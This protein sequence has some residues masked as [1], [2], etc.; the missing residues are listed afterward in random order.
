MGVAGEYA[1]IASDVKKVLYRLAGETRKR[2]LNVCT[3]S[4]T[5]NFAGRMLA[6]ED[7]AT[8][9]LEF[10]AGVVTGIQMKSGNSRVIAIE[11]VDV[12]TM[13]KRFN[14]R[15]VSKRI[16]PKVNADLVPDGYYIEEPYGNIRYED[17]AISKAAAM[18]GAAFLQKLA[19]TMPVNNW[20]RVEPLGK[21]Q[22]Q[23]F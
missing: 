4:S 1:E 13:E 6:W 2:A 16:D 19:A 10:A 7:R 5:K 18:M 8:Q 3:S 22:C 11:A 15:F 14:C 23:L 17:N 20:V 9:G 21:F 12:A